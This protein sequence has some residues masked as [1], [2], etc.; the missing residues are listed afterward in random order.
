M[1]H[2]SCYEAPINAIFIEMFESEILLD[3]FVVSKL[4]FE[5]DKHT[6]VDEECLLF[7]QRTRILDDRILVYDKM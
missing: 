7:D 4:L 5:L 1:L 6:N 3:F 2:E